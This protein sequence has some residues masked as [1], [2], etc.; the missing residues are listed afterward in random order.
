MKASRRKSPVNS[1][2][3]PTDKPFGQVPLHTSLMAGGMQLQP[4]EVARASLRYCPNRICPLLAEH[5]LR[6]GNIFHGKTGR[7]TRPQPQP[8]V[9]FHVTIAKC[10]NTGPV[11]VC[12][13]HVIE[14]CRA[15]SRRL[16]KE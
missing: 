4:T 8:A 3:S 7:P 9:N 16:D 12:A 15:G 11:V 5:L 14:S 2:N 10:Q 6:H 13:G 1:V